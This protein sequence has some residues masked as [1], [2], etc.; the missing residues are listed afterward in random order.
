MFAR[1]TLETFLL[2]LS[3]FTYVFIS[4]FPSIKNALSLKNTFS[5]IF[6][7]IDASYVI[8]YLWKKDIYPMYMQY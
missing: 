7:W 2:F 8:E 6:L 1:F 5:E 4:C 3:Y